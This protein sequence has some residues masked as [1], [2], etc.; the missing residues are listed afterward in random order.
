MK[1]AKAFFLP[2]FIVL[3][4]VT[5]KDIF[6]CSCVPAA[7]PFLKVAPKSMLV[8]RGRILRYA[9]DGEAKTEM[10]VEVLETLAGEAPKRVVSISGDT[11]NQCRPYVSSFPIG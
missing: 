3:I 10:D 8:I 7:N 5:A 9:G 11:G 1:H 2:L 4:A 6:A